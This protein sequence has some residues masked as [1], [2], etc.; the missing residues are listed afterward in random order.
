MLFKE[1]KMKIILYYLFFKMNLKVIASYEFDVI[2]AIIGSAI[3]T[4]IQF[5]LILIISQ[6]ILKINGYTLP[7]LLLIY[8]LSEASFS[9]WRCLYIHTISLP[10]FIR[11]GELDQFLL[12]P[13]SPLFL[14][15]TYGFDED[16][17][18]DLIVSIIIVVISLI[19][20]NHVFYI[21]FIP[22]IVIAG[23][24]IFAGISLLFSI[25]SFWTVGHNDMANI[26]YDMKEFTKYPMQL[27]DKKIRWILTVIFPLTFVATIP[28]Q[29]IQS[30]SDYSILFLFCTLIFSFYFFKITRV[31]W[32]KSFSAYQSTG[33]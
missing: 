33:S 18:G 7:L 23:S 21:F 30:G 2:F 13:I 14:I 6:Y 25:I 31:I 4:L 16:A 19:Q 22:F 5:S 29:I 1:V 15:M 11:T 10:Y 27:Y 20:F 12:R 9:L 3:N 26:V 24:L 32:S 8:G 17:W 28:A